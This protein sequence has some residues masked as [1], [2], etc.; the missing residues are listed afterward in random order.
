[1]KINNILLLKAGGLAVFV[2]GILLTVTNLQQMPEFTRKLE[3]KVNNLKQLRAMRNAG[4]QYQAALGAFQALTN[5]APVSLSGLAATC[6]TNAV[7]E[8]RARDSHRLKNDWT[9]TQV[10]VIYS[11]IDLNLLSPFVTA[12]ESQR[13]PWKL[14][15]CEIEALRPAGGFGRTVLVFE[16]LKKTTN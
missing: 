14:I 10:E 15:E 8:I 13:P 11:E 3:T 6:I 12:A 2:I 1:M 7:P 9:L 16:S 4:G 5:P